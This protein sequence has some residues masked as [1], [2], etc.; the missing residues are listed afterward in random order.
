M[1]LSV[2]A[3][4]PWLKKDIELLEQVQKRAV[5]MVVGLSSTSYNEKL[6]ELKLLS[7]ED[8]RLRGDLIQVWKYLHGLNTGCDKV[9]TLSNKQHSR[10]SRHTTKRLNICRVEGRLEIRKNFYTVRVADKWNSLPC[11]VQEAEDIDTFKKEL[12]AFMFTI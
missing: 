8:R 12:D 4:S 11:W 1:E 2:Q 3:W 10:S 7:L 6:K 5:D 9:F